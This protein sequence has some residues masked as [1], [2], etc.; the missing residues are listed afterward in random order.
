MRK[1]RITRKPLLLVAAL[2][3]AAL[4][5]FGGV[6]LS[7]SG[8][9]GVSL[10]GHA[11]KGALSLGQARE[12]SFPVYYPGD[13]VEGQAL[14]VILRGYNSSP[15]NDVDFIYGTCQPSSEA[16]CPAPIEVQVWPACAR[17]LS[18]YSP[19]VQSG[20]EERTV[21]GVPAA[22]FS[23]DGGRLEL[24]TET[25]TIVI[26]AAGGR[27]QALRVANSLRGLNNGVGAGKPLPAPAAG[28]VQ[29]KLSC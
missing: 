5:S 22:Y 28:A 1:A 20:R 9:G 10:P 17:N 4:A 13:R 12:A 7:Q 15:L 27:D 6:A 24:Q 2:A 8:S 14:N 29:G 18:S 26:F 25:S 23:T 3:L 19:S 16:G 11:P 21:R